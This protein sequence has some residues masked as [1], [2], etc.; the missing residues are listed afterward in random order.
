MFVN[1]FIQWAQLISA[2]MVNQENVSVQPNFPS[3]FPSQSQKYRKYI[4]FNGMKGAVNCLSFNPSGELL[5]SGG[6]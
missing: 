6:M 2:M 5:A 1:I 3:Y 4:K